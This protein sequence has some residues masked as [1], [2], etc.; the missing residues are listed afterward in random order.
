[1]AEKE[2]S[3]VFCCLRTDRGREF[4]SNEFSNFGKA[5]G[6]KQQ[7]T[8]AYTPQQNK[9][10]ECKNRTIMNMACC[11]LEEK[12]LPKMFLSEVVKWAYHVLNK[13]STYVVKDKTPKE[14]WSGFKPSVKHFKVFGCVGNFHVPYA[15]ILKLYARSQKQVFIGYSEKSKGYKIR[16]PL[17]MKVTICREVIVEE[18][19]YWNL[20]GEMPNQIVMYLTGVKP[21]RKH[22]MN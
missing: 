19:G 11:V 17:T 7:L 18:D 15:R 4:N 6:T 21:M 20:G 2:N 3:L 5:Q 1:M 13:S 10:A 22:M 8:T 9:V 12:R 16:N 14:C